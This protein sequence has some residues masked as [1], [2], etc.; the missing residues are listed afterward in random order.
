MEN[1]M[2]PLHLERL[3][4]LEQQADNYRKA[5]EH[6]TGGPVNGEPWQVLAAR[7]LD[8]AARP[9]ENV[10]ALRVKSLAGMV[11]VRDAYICMANNKHQSTKG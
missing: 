2:T 6:L 11:Y 3:K 4:A 8:N 9:Y 7:A 1:T 5:L 10:L